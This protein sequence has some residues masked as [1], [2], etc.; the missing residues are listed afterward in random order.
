M[1]QGDPGR[2]HIDIDVQ[3][4]LAFFTI[5]SFT[6]GDL[7]GQ[8]G[9]DLVKTWQTVAEAFAIQTGFA[10]DLFQNKKLL[11]EMLAATPSY[12]L[13]EHSSSR[14]GGPPTVSADNVP[15]AIR[16]LVQLVQS[17]QGVTRQLH[18]VLTPE[19]MIM[20]LRA[21]A[22]NRGADIMRSSNNGSRLQEGEGTNSNMSDQHTPGTDTEA[23]TEP[24]AQLQTS[25]AS[26]HGS[27]TQPHRISQVRS[28]ASTGSGTD[29]PY[30][31]D[32]LIDN[33][34]G[35]LLQLLRSLLLVM[36]LSCLSYVENI[37]GIMTSVQFVFWRTCLAKRD[38]Y[39]TIVDEA[40]QAA[41]QSQQQELQAIAASIVQLAMHVIRRSIQ[42]TSRSQAAGTKEAAALSLGYQFALEGS[43]CLALLTM[44]QQFGA[45]DFQHAICWEI[46]RFGELLPTLLQPKCCIAATH[47]TVIA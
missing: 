12:L 28:K 22:A 5:N 18:C 4:T 45:P 7:E 9:T 8:K 29:A 2:C 24:H 10:F 43:I 21:I 3:P 44:L 1:L 40:M 26:Q 19:M 35:R 6:P 37:S 41:N 46:C 42:N 17:L 25:L 14:R 32:L 33:S 27:D 15:P 11:D 31:T 20:S 39:L 38:I 34:P 13:P 36:K 23:E 30:Q 16:P 47:S